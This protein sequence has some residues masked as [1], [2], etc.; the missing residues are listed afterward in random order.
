MYLLLILIITSTVTPG[1]TESV[2]IVSDGDDVTLP[3]ENLIDGQKNCDRTTWSFIRSMLKVTLFEDGQLNE[4]KKSGG[5][6]V[7]ANCSLV[8]K[9][10]TIKDVGRYVCRQLTAGKGENSSVLLSVFKMTEQ[11]SNDSVVLNCSV[12]DYNY[13]RHKVEWLYEG[14]GNISSHNHQSIPAFH[15]F[16]ALTA[17]FHQNSPLYRSKCKVTNIDTGKIQLFTFGHQSKVQT[18]GL[19]WWPIVVSV[20]STSILIFIVMFIKWKKTKE[21]MNR[22]KGDTEPNLKRL[23]EE[24]ILG[25]EPT[26]DMVSCT[27]TYSTADLS[28]T[29]DSGNQDVVYSTV[30]LKGEHLT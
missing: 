7:T 22:S 30:K 9:N 26:E 21:C 25:P 15:S 5:L 23:P 18:T 14:E 24:T 28:S 6:N 2:F 12:V 11:K 8:I 27:V 10:V 1:N 3:C 13:H 16:V 19:H 4:K 29:K 20:A 17:P